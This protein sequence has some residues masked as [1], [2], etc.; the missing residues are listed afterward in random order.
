[1]ES[2]VWENLEKYSPRIEQAP[3]G[4]AYTG[5]YFINCKLPEQKYK[6]CIPYIVNH[7][8]SKKIVKNEIEKILFHH[9]FKEQSY[10]RIRWSNRGADFETD[11][12]GC[13]LY[14]SSD[15][16]DYGYG[17]YNV[18]TLEQAFVLFTALS[19]YLRRVW[20][21]LALFTNKPSE[22]EKWIKKHSLIEKTTQT[23]ELNSKII[24]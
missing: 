4:G 16:G 1:M 2:T 11:G 13:I 7:P 3:Q 6:K 8:K 22:A 24:Y 10:L 19:V 9:K 17:S 5:Y 15:F 14:P 21:A 23:I 12:N 18:D 20:V